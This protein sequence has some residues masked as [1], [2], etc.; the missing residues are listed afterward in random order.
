[1]TKA[2]QGRFSARGLISMQ[3]RGGDLAAPSVI[4]C[5]QRVDRIESAADVDDAMKNGSAN[6]K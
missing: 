2:L 1:M 6:A 4:D 5:G 3:K